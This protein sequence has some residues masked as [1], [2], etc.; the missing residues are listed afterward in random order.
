M[1][2]TVPGFPLHAFAEYFEKLEF[3][4]VFEDRCR[5][6][7]VIVRSFGFEQFVYLWMKDPSGPAPHDSSN[8]IAVDFR[9]AAW[10]EEYDACGLAAHDPVRLATR[11]QYTPILYEAVPISN[12]AQSRFMDRARTNGRQKNGLCF[13]IPSA[14]GGQS[15]F[16]AVER[17]ETPDAGVVLGVLSAVKAFHLFAEAEFTAKRAVEFGVSP[18]ELRILTAVKSGLRSRQ[19][20]QEFGLTEGYVNNVMSDLRGRFGK[21]NTLALLSYL[22][23]A[24]VVRS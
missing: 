13:A 17:E 3:S 11:D 19:V 4:T 6:L 20:A 2:L 15:G 1:S 16:G 18:S 24:G 7:E 12:S 8:F 5:A 21:G 23:R 9:D 10:I 14:G 22:E